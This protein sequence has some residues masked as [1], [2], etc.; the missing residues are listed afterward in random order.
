LIS[1][2]ACR[3]C[4]VKTFLIN[5]PS[6]DHSTEADPAEE[7]VA[8]PSQYGA[9]TGNYCEATTFVNMEYTEYEFCPSA[10]QAASGCRGTPGQRTA[11]SSC[12]RPNSA[13]KQHERVRRA[14]CHG[15]SGPVGIHSSTRNSPGQR[16]AHWGTDRRRQV[17]RPPW[18]TFTIMTA[19]CTPTLSVLLPDFGYIGLL[20]RRGRLLRGSCSPS[21]RSACG[22]LQIPPRD[23]HPCRPTDSPHCRVRRGLAPP[24][25][26][27]PPG[28]HKEPRLPGR[29]A[30][31]I[32]QD[33]TY[34]V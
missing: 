22:F 19:A 24:G 9:P 29:Q 7:T 6:M 12:P 20:I 11:P 13:P 4:F 25:D 33:L 23:G 1:K 17:G 31:L 18:A 32:Q 27:A 16:A 30:R 26:C 21:Q 8:P 28:R 15:R 34:S 14:A 10:L 5:R 3:A 2:L